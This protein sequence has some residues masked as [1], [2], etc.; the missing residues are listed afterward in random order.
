M[1]KCRNVKLQRCRGTEVGPGGADTKMHW[2]R[3]D[4]EVEVLV[5][6]HS[7][8]RCRGVDMEVL[9]GCIGGSGVAEVHVQ[10]R[11]RGGT[12]MDV[13]KFLLFGAKVLHSTKL[14]VQ[15]IVQS[16]E[17]HKI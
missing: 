8:T 13:L 17:A 2:S 4:A 10:R 1:Q 16:S 14:I 15:G 11:C 7:T 5:E 3:R 12:D 6:V 9:K